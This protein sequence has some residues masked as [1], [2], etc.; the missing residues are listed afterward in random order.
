MNFLLEQINALWAPLELFL[1]IFVACYLFIASERDD[2]KI[3][4]FLDHDGPVHIQMAVAVLS[5]HIGDMGVRWIV[6]YWRYMTARGYDLPAYFASPILLV[7]AVIAVVGLLCTIR[8]ITNAWCRNWAWGTALTMSLTF[9]FITESKM[10]IK[11]L[12][13]IN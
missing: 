4:N 6:W 7:F 13:T 12:S 10:I 5:F 11:L 9:M 1:V 3:R 8:V 2:I